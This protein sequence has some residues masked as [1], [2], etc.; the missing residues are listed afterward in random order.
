MPENPFSIF[1]PWK[2]HIGI[3]LFTKK[4]DSSSD[5]LVC[6]RMGGHDYAALRQV[7]GTGTIVVREQ[8]HRMEEADG[9]ITDQPSL[10]LT[11]R[12]ADCQTFVVYAPEQ[13]VVGL[14]HVGWRGLKAGALPK[15]FDQLRQSF[16]ITPDTTYVGAAPSLCQHCA[17]FTDPLREL[18]GIP[19]VLIKGRAANL[20][21]WAETQLNT[22][23]VPVDHRERLPDCT[24]CD[25]QHYWT[26]RGGDKEAVQQGKTNVLACVLLP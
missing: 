25:P 8:M 9:L 14:L 6:S 16:G 21:G 2:S 5:E 18:A 7:H 13:N 23:G 20:Q 26:Y 24:C 17:E 22:I 15:F 10:V 11:I 19:E 4:D 3:G 1:T 12:M